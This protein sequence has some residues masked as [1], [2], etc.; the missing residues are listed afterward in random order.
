[1]NQTEK[2]FYRRYCLT[3][4]IKREVYNEIYKQHFISVVCY[5]Y[6]LEE[7]YDTES[8]STLE[9]SV[10]LTI[11][12]CYEMHRQKRCYRAF[13]DLGHEERFSWHMSKTL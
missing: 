7:S 8:S 1:M 13:L 4:S 11:Y 6:A 12:F 10:K 9:A 2:T 5:S 3:N